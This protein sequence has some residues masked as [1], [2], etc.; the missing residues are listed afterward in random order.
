[1]S[2][3]E[4]QGIVAELPS[5]VEGRIFRRTAVGGA[6]AETVLHLATF[7]LPPQVADFGGGAVTLMG[8]TDVFL[9]LFEYGQDSLG[10]RLFDRHGMPRRLPPESFSPFTLRRGIAGQAGTQWF[11]TE[12]GRPFT[13]YVVIGSHSQRLRL[14][15]RVDG[16]LAGITIA[17]RAAVVAR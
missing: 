4:G 2:R 13:L 5:G 17:P 10:K 12:S 14:A 15:R 3:L 16:M 7:P 9:S 1:V 8:P 6:Q 11:F